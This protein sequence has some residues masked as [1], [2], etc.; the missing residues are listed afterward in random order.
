MRR[1]AA[2]RPQAFRD[3]ASARAFFGGHM[4][5]SPSQVETYHRCRFAYFCRYGLGL[6]PRSRAELSPLELGNVIHLALEELLRRY[7]PLC[8]GAALAR[9][10]AGGV[11]HGRPGAD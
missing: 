8:H 10:H 1:A 4:R 9:L 11:L 5:L 2:A 6:T 3:P 7:T